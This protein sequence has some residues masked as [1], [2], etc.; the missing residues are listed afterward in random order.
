M[1]KNF[2]FDTLL[3][4]FEGDQ[5]KSSSFLTEVHIPPDEGQRI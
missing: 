2:V 5:N 4:T 3:Y 1:V